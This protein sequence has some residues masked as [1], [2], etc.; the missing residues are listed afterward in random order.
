[1]SYIG[2]QSNN[3][4]SPNFVKE[5]FTGTGSTTTFTLTN[6]VPG[7]NPDN[8]L[9]V[10]NNVIQEPSIAYTIGDNSDN[11]PKVLTFTGTPANGDDIYVVHRGIGTF[12]RTPPAGSVDTAQLATGLRNMTTDAFSGTGSA[13]QFTL[14]Q[15]P[16]SASSVMVFVDGILQKLTTNYTISGTT[17]DFGSGNA[18]DN[19][20]E[21]EVKHLGLLTTNQKV[22]DNTITE[23]MLQDNSVSLAKLKTQI[24]FGLVTA[25]HTSLDD[26][27]CVTGSV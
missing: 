20:A 24:D 23:A 8:I 3:R 11:Q 7:G 18:P 22:A 1:M 6:E 15:T 25:V 17:L 21:I 4:V 27:G 26:F 2:A 13:T 9:V 16:S 12:Q 10:V 14:S 19:N 5:N